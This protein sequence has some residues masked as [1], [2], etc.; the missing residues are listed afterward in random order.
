MATVAYYKDGVPYEAS[1]QVIITITNPTG[2]DKNTFGNGSLD[3]VTDYGMNLVTRPN[4]VSTTIDPLAMAKNVPEIHRQE[5]MAQ[6][7]ETDQAQKALDQALLTAQQNTAQRASEFL[8]LLNAGAAA[9]AQAKVAYQNAVVAELN[10]K[11][12]SERGSIEYIDK[13]IM[14]QKGRIFWPVSQED[15]DA[16]QVYINAREADKAAIDVIIQGDQQ[17]IASMQSAMQ[18]VE[19]ETEQIES[20]LKFTADFL[21]EQT[22]KFG[23]KAGQTA[24]KLADAAQGNTLRNADE[25]LAAFSKHQANIYARFGESDRQ[26]M[27]NALASLDANKLSQDLAKYSRALSLVSYGL[28]AFALA[29]ELQNSLNTGDFKPF[30]LKV[31]SMG[32]GLLATELVAWVFAVMTGSVIGILGFGLLMTLTGALINEQ[33]MDDVNNAL[34]N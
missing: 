21:K 25:A 12:A 28:D 13:D 33:L 10:A 34:F 14:M 2:Y 31:E 20:A 15:A 16:A 17:G 18:S 11:I 1:G 23:E 22:A 3:L 4:S 5:L 27:A 29:K 30:F 6:M 32:V 9:R 26:A 19:S 24:Q 8:S 7:E